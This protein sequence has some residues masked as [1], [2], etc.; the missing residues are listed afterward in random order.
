LIDTI[1]PE[2]FNQAMKGPKHYDR[3]LV[4]EHMTKQTIENLPVGKVFYVTPG[5]RDDYDEPAIFVTPDRRLVM[6]KDHAIDVDDQY[7]PTPLERVGIMHEFIPDGLTGGRDV[8]VA[9]LRYIVENELVDIDPGNCDAETQEEYMAYLDMLTN[10]VQFDAFIAPKRGAEVNDDG[11]VPWT[12]HGDPALL[13]LLKTLRK[14]GDKRM[15]KYMQREA[16]QVANVN[17]TDAVSAVAVA[18]VVTPP[19]KPTQ[20]QPEKEKAPAYLASPF[21]HGR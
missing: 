3:A 18:A 12:S 11:V 17:R 7:P 1:T 15:R 19:E 16:K 10:T 13:P 20:A 9:D 6:S 4:P 8:Y 5:E 14:H 2:E 21:S